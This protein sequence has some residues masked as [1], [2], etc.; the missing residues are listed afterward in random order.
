ME[1]NLVV[2]EWFCRVPLNEYRAVTN[3]S[4]L[5]YGE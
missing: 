2:G 1:M 4:F 5:T 3:L